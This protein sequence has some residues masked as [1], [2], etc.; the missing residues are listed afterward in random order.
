MAKSDVT[1][2]IKATLKY[3]AGKCYV[4][5]FS[6]ALLHDLRTKIVETEISGQ[7]YF[8]N[9]GVIHLESLIA[10]FSREM[11]YNPLRFHLGDDG[12]Y[13]I[14]TPQYNV[15]VTI[16]SLLKD[17][18]T[19]WPNG[20]VNR[21]I[22]VDLTDIKYMFLLRLRDCFKR[23]ANI[24]MQDFKIARYRDEMITY[25]AGAPEIAMPADLRNEMK[26][27]SVL[28]AQR[29][30]G[31]R[32]IL[33][34]QRRISSLENLIKIHQTHDRGFSMELVAERDSLKAQLDVLVAAGLK[35]RAL[36]ARPVKRPVNAPA[37]P[38]NLDF[39][40]EDTTNDA[41]EREAELLSTLTQEHSM[42]KTPDVFIDYIASHGIHRR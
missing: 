5:R 23:I 9:P 13:P 25:F 2:F 18:Q 30:H 16:N 20:I 3:R 10:A 36:S 6:G 4:G 32:M 33:D 22:V 28:S 21:F 39:Y 34:L 35:K 37:N 12:R 31:N 8:L 14:N 11:S 24:N 19:L 42:G 29:R 40:D 15:A 38:S 41:Y 26:E 7:G 1:S 27:M 17:F